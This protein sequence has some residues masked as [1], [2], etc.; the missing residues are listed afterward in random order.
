MVG[1]FLFNRLS[2]NIIFVVLTS[3]F[4]CAGA[5]S[6]NNIT[7]KREDLINRKRISP[8]TYSSLG[9]IVVIASFSLGMIFSLFLSGTSIFISSLL[10][11]LGIAY[12]LFRIKRFFLIK[13]IYTGFGVPILFLLGAASINVETLWY[14]FLLSSF[15]FAGSIISDIRDYEGDKKTCIKTLPVYMGYLS[16]ESDTE[17]N[18]KSNK[19]A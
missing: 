17:N 10:L 7:D 16:R 18:G 3:F 6:Y 14:Y 8:L 13:N 1:Y 15:S 4:L 9:N 19:C 2:I 12:S 5:Y 11:I